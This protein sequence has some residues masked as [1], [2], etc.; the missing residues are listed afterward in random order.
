MPIYEYRCKS[1]GAISEFLTGV[2]KDEPISCKQCGSFEMERVLSVSSFSFGS[3][4]RAP[5]RTCCG[6]EERCETPPCSSGG[7]CRRG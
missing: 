2:G 5:G 6:R 7:G 3:G 1:C 4:E